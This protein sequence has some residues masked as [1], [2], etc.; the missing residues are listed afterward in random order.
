MAITKI[1]PGKPFL[2][3]EQLENF[4]NKNCE[5]CKNYI[6]CTIISSAS[7][8]FENKDIK[9]FPASILVELRD[10]NNDV[11]RHHSCLNFSYIH[12]I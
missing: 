5:S 6:D 3:E 4:I 2:N 12:N 11:I 10:E 1:K 7:L 8:S 9:L